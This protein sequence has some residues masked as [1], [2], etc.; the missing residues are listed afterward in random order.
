MT[1]R[2]LEELNQTEL[3]KVTR[4]LLQVLGVLLKEDELYLV[5]YLRTMQMMWQGTLQ[6]DEDYPLT[7]DAAYGVNPIFSNT[8][9]LTPEQKYRVITNN[10]ESEWELSELMKESLKWHKENPTDDWNWEESLLDGLWE[11][12]DLLSAIFPWTADNLEA[13]AWKYWEEDETEA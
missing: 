9:D 1:E 5:Q 11:D 4:E 10:L 7:A 12:E 2:T 13:E 6:W 3:S 8:D